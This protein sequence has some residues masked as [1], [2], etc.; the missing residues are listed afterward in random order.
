MNNQEEILQKQNDEGM[1]KCQYAARHYYNKAEKN[2]ITAFICSIISL[3]FI[4]APEKTSPL[5][6]AAIL[7]IPLAFDAASLISYWRMGVAVSSAALL[8][9]FF[10]DQVLGINPSS[11]TDQVIRKV[12]SLI[13][14][15]S[16]KNKTECE[17]QMSNTGRDNPPGVKNWYEFSHHYSDSD[18]VFE[19]QK[20]N[21][22]WNNELCHRRL[23]VFGVVLLSVIFF[24]IILVFFLHVSIL[25]IIVCLLSAI[26]TFADR[27]CEN[28]KYIRLSMKI[29]DR[30]ETLDVS[31]NQALI[32]SLQLLISQ[33]REL[34]VVEKNRIHRNNSKVFS[35]RY[36]QITKGH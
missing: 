13:I 6:S 10:D 1:L 27:F 9:N 33:R 31:K 17:F 19:C 15:A 20:Q 24:G 35:E 14:N 36:E 18:V 28:C 23:F 32:S 3:L 30:C 4:L 12:E 21:C 8:R 22:W 5:Y 16:V 29:D 2:S 26:I 34:R 7:L 25:R 11:N